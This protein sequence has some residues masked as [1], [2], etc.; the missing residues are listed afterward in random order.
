MPKI[1]NIEVEE[2]VDHILNTRE[3]IRETAT[4]FGV[5]KSFVFSKIKLYDG[6][7][8]QELEEILQDNVKKS[9]F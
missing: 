6:S 2:I 5:S 4:Y 3:S 1:V 9:R 8:K 7:K